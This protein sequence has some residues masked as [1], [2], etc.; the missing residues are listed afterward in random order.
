MDLVFGISCKHMLEGCAMSRWPVSITVVYLEIH[1]ETC[2]SKAYK[3]PSG[4]EAELLD[5][6]EIISNLMFGRATLK[7]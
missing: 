7:T 3:K 2:T 4:A 1:A 5:T 6:R